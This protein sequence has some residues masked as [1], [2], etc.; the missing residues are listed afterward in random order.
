M[1]RIG[2]D[3][4]RALFLAEVLRGARNVSDERGGAP[5]GV[6]GGNQVQPKDCAVLRTSR[7]AG[8]LPPLAFGQFPPKYFPQKEGGGGRAQV[9]EGVF[10]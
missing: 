3:S 8:A 4:A 1:V 7:R 5:K 10:S 9:S 2:D 6:R